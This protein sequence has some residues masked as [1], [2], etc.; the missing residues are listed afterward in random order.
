MHSGGQCSHP[1][2]RFLENSCEFSL[3]H[4]VPCELSCH[5]SAL[6][7]RGSVPRGPCQSSPGLAERAAR[8]GAW[9]TP[10]PGWD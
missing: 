2:Q 9:P 8:E 3:S 1:W 7:S 4:K 5:H 10:A 6:Q